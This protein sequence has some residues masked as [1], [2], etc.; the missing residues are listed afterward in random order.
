MTYLK[1]LMILFTE[2]NSNLVVKHVA[3]VSSSNDNIVHSGKEELQ[4]N[5]TSA[6]SADAAL[7]DSASGFE[8]VRLAYIYIYINQFTS[9]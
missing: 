1:K 4:L 6:F 2:I 8:M 5:G 9:V 7:I 3:N